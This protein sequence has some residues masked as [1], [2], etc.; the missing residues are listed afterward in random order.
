MIE[1][2]G[3]LGDNKMIGVHRTLLPDVKKHWSQSRRQ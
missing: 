2:H 3:T 1:V